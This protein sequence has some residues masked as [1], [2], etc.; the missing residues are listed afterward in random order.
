MCPHRRRPATPLILENCGTHLLPQIPVPL[1]DF[2]V[3]GRPKSKCI[4][5]W[6]L[7]GGCSEEELVFNTP[8][9]VYSAAS[10]S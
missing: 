3:S 10:S 8:V 2:S 7:A 4:D 5:V 9:A 1:G 6:A